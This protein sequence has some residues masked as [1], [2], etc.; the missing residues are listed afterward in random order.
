MRAK[1]K[2]CEEIRLAE[3]RPFRI[4]RQINTKR[5]AA[6]GAA[7]DVEKALAVAHDAVGN[8]ETQPRADP[9]SLVVKNGSSEGETIS[10]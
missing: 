2:R 5:R 10:A 6:A 8:A 3:L 7:V 1:K 4:G 9:R